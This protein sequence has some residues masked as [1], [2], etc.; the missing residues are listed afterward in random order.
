MASGFAIWACADNLSG[1]AALVIG[2]DH[3]VARRNR[4]QDRPRA[5]NDIAFHPRRQRKCRRLDVFAGSRRTRSKIKQRV[6]SIYA[7]VSQMAHCTNGNF[8]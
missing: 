4:D 7:P 8:V 2:Y 1:L 6:G 5:L 3:A